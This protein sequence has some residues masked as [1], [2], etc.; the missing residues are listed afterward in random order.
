MATGF[1]Q[2]PG[3]L[4]RGSVQRLILACWLSGFALGDT[5]SDLIS[6]AQA[7]HGVPGEEAARFLLEHMPPEDRSALSLE[8]LT[9]NLELAFKARAEFS[10]AAD[11][12]EAI[13]LNDVL[14]YAV[15]D[16]PRHPHPRPRKS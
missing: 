12:P 3:L 10:W 15:F 4:H 14:P 1:D 7:N 9:E 6:I 2:R 16:E 5:A 8:Y 13:F 11:V